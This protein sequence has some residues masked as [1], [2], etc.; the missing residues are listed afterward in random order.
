MT[1]FV[2]V[3]KPHQPLFIGVGSNKWKKC[4]LYPADLVIKHKDFTYKRAKKRYNN[5]ENVTKPYEKPNPLFIPFDQINNDIALIHLRYNM[6]F[7]KQ[8]KPIHL[9]TNFARKD[10]HKIMLLTWKIV[11]SFKF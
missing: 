10:Q 8:V 2:N 6:T 5:R 1:C 4:I 7:S 3:P 9:N 11:S